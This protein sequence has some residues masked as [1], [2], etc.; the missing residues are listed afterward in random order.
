MLSKF[1][2]QVGHEEGHALVPYLVRQSRA[3]PKPGVKV[4]LRPELRLV[5]GK[6]ILARAV[7]IALTPM[8]RSTSLDE[9]QNVLSLNS[10]AEGVLPGRDHSLQLC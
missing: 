5:G 2:Y 9:A 1:K 4:L 10:K 7:G 8:G 3:L 6:P